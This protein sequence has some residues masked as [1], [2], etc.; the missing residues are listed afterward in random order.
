MRLEEAIEEFRMALLADGITRKTVDW[1]VWLLQR[2]P[3]ALVRY[4]TASNLLL[5]TITTS[6]LRAYIV[7]LRET[8]STK[9]GAVMSEKT[10]DD[11]IRTLHRFFS[12]CAN[13]YGT[14]NPM[15]RIAFPKVSEAKPKATSIDDIKR[16]L[17]ACGDDFYGRRNRAIIFFLLD[18]GCRA[19][20]L[21]GLKLDDLDMSKRRA[22]VTEKR[23]KSRYVQFTDRTAAMLDGWFGERVNGSPYVF[24][25]EGGAALTP[26]GLRQVLKKLGARAG[27]EGRVNPHS[28]RHLF[29]KL[30]LESGGD[31]P[32][33]SALMGH[34]QVQTTIT[35]YI[36]FSSDE[37]RQRHARFS[38]VNKL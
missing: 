22:L 31:L 13:E 37:L 27:V 29:A 12:W 9:T 36:H 24:H 20:G 38:P 23:N 18:T 10:I 25:S 32:S 14:P 15:A 28:F 4:A 2:S 7:Q 3:H 11:Y 26:N 8:V 1:Y 5:S 30:W 19:A 6:H 16:M 33:L 35:N 34:A 21:C 17:A